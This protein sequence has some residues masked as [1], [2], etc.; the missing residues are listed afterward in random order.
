MYNFAR[1]GDMKTSLILNQSPDPG[2]NDSEKTIAILGIPRGGTTLVAAAV[3]ALGINLGPEKNMREYHFE[4][5]TMH[6]PNLQTQYA[7]IEQRNN[8]HK[9]WGWK[10]PTGIESVRRVLFTLRNPHIIIVFR[11][12]LASI[13]GEMRFDQEYC[14]MV[15]RSFDLLVESTMRWWAA[16]WEFITHTSL[17]TMLVSYERALY[18]PHEFGEELATFLQVELTK[19]KRREITSRINQQGGYLVMNEGNVE[20][21]K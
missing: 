9:I 20:V 3:D 10:D 18:H 13:Q 16:N 11:D 6:S 5:Q 14:P 4:D 7:Y 21:T 8:E 15:S 12:M 1:I 17:P 2:K 19:D